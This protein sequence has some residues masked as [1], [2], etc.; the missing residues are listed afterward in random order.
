M[1]KHP[2]EYDL[3]SPQEAV[4]AALEADRLKALRDV[5]AAAALG[6]M[7]TG[8]REYHERNM[9]LVQ[10]KRAYEYADVM[11]EARKQ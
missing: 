11:L 1:S 4:E 3:R 5:F 8:G 9:Q 10:A 2:T 6:A 7:I